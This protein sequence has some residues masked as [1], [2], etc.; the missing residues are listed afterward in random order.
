MN[1]YDRR[2]FRPLLTRL[3]E[4]CLLSVAVPKHVLGLPS[5]INHT[6]HHQVAKVPPAKVSPAKVPNAT[7]P[8]AKVPHATVPPAKVPHAK[9]PHVKVSKLPTLAGGAL[10]AMPDLAAIVSVERFGF[11]APRIKV[12]HIDLPH[13]KVPNVNVPHV[14]VPNINVPHVKV[15]HVKVPHV[16]VPNVKV[17]HVKV[18][19]LPTLAG[20]SEQA[21][22]AGGRLGFPIAAGIMQARNANRPHE[23]LST[24][25]KAVLRPAFG[26]L[27]D[28]V[29]IVWGTEPLD[30]VTFGPYSVKSDTTA[31]TFGLA[32]YV[33]Y[34]REN[35]SDAERISIETHE[36]THAQQY[37]RFGESLGEFGYQYFLNYKKANQNYRD[38]SLEVEAYRQ[39]S[40]L[41]SKEL[42]SYASQFGTKL[43]VISFTNPTEVPVTFSFRWSPKGPS[44]T[45][46]LA[47]GHTDFFS[48]LPFDQDGVIQQGDLST[49]DNGIT[50]PEVQIASHSTS[51]TLDRDR[52]LTP[53][54]VTVHSLDQ[55][56]AFSDGRQYSFF[57]DSTRAIDVRSGK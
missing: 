25:D 38:N 56:P 35:L 24:S 51:P 37:V 23:S 3:E 8:H 43:A 5:P 28:R 52:T 26:S 16:K 32:I 34:P 12:P 46:T 9:V 54:L 21:W 22:G 19:K 40:T 14:K 55:K 36:L 11:H 48:N 47:P 4:K 29:T 49:A 20:V 6:Q 13:V 30:S 33:K 15:P 31:Q 39:E 44:T 10:R 50:R 53:N 57:L 45:K 1:T 17:P 42:Q 27:V 7:A 2:R 41:T 18:P